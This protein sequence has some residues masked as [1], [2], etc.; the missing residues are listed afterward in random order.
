MS[1]APSSANA[2]RSAPTPAA[3]QARMADILGIDAAHVSVKATTSER[4]GFTGREEGHRRHCHRHAGQNHDPLFHLD[5]KYL[6]EREGLAPR[7][8][9]H[10]QSPTRKPP[11]HD[12]P[13]RPPSSISAISGPF[14]A[15]GARPPPSSPR[16]GSIS[17]AA[18]FWVALLIPVAILAGWWAHRRRDPG[19]TRSRPVRDRHRRGRRPVDRAFA[20]ADRRRPMRAMPVGRRWR[21]GPVG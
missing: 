20:G 19:Q 7:L 2:Q 1:T 6:G 12:P 9:P 16:S 4:L 17:S 8:R 10:P 3:M 15:H 13:H 14:P 18:G 21:S 5:P 11:A